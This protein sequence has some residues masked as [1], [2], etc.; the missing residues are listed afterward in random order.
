MTVTAEQSSENSLSQMLFISNMEKNICTEIPAAVKPPCTT[1]STGTESFCTP[2]E[3]SVFNGE[4]DVRHCSLHPSMTQYPRHQKIIDLVF[5]AASALRC[6]VGTACFA[7]FATGAGTN[8]LLGAGFAGVGG[9]DRVGGA[10][11]GLCCA[12]LVGLD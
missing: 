6:P 1:P 8:V 2:F 9:A 4:K 11:V 3:H 5:T 10:F 7:S 12:T